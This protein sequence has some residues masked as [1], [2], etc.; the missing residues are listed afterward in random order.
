[1]NTNEHSNIQSALACV[2]IVLNVIMN[3]LVIA[4]VARYPQLREDRTTLFMFLLPGLHTCPSTPLW[5]WNKAGSCGHG[6][7]ISE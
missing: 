5:L 2:I 1:M 6:W 3:S 4:V 7:I